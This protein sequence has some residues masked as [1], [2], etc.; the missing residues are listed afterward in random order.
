MQTGAGTPQS[1]TLRLARV[2]KSYPDKHVIDVVFL[3]D[4]GFASGVGVSNVWGSQNH[5]IVYLP[6]VAEP[7]DGHWS[8][9]MSNTNDSL[10]L[11]GYFSGMPYAVGFCFPAPNGMG[12]GKNMMML[13]HISGSYI[14]IDAEG[15]IRARATGR[16]W[17]KLESDTGARVQIGVKPG[18]IEL[19]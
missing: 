13:K 6:E 2:V 18:I 12:Q 8:V 15:N 3:D 5:G 1:N 17:I 9:E 7:A 16:G 14:S 4:G 19:N 10:A 11:V